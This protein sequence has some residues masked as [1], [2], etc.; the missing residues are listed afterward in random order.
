M[1]MEEDHISIDRLLPIIDHVLMGIKAIL[2][3][4]TDSLTRK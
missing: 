1:I 2:T 4:I 3:R